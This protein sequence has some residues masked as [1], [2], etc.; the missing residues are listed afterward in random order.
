MN[1]LQQIKTWSATHHPRWLVI[2]RIGLGL[3]L[4][5]KGIN[6]MRDSQMLESLIYGGRTLAENETHWLPILITWAN[7]LGGFF[8]MIGL[9]T[10]FIALTQIP[11]LIGAIIFVN[12]QKGGF[13][14]ES[15]LGL[16]ILTLV[17]VIFFLIEGSGPISL[18]AY[19]ESNR[20][21]KGQGRNLP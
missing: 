16:A 5:A 4:F 12:A 13:A 6:F 18:D 20:D 19:F 3:F 9:M 2:L 14:P 11:I 1:T 15:E 21:S 17:L 10:R 8:L 7:L